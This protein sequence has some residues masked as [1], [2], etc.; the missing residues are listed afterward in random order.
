MFDSAGEVAKRLA[1]ELNPNV[2]LDSPVSMITQSDEGVT[3]VYADCQTVSAQ[4]VVVA[5]PPVLRLK[6]QFEPPLSARFVQ[7]M[8][9]TPMSSKWKVLAVYPTAF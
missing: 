6:I 3:V 8:Q 2:M 9:R 4:A 1:T 5:V 7:L